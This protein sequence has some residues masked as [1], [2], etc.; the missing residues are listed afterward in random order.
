MAKEE[1]KGTMYAPRE[2]LHVSQVTSTLKEIELDE[3]VEDWDVL[4]ISAM[5]RTINPI[6]AAMSLAPTVVA[7]CG[8]FSTL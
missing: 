1:A 2:R 8:L 6:S 5:S 7:L 3:Q 4:A